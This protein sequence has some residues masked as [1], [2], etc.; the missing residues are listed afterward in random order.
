M[1]V[2]IQYLFSDKTRRNESEKERVRERER[3]KENDYSSGY[4]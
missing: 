2:I 1:Q 4:R 3:E